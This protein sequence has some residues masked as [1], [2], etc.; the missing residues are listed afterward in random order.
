MDGRSGSSGADVAPA[1]QTGTRLLVDARRAAGE[2]RWQEAEERLH[3]VEQRS[4][5]AAEDLELLATAASLRGDRD[6]ARRARLRAYQ[7]FVNQ[8]ERRRA[9]RCGALIGL[10]LLGSGEL[11]EATGCLPMSLSACSAWVGQAQILL[12]GEGECAE[13]G[14]VLIPA[15]YEQLTVGTD[16]E[17][18]AADAGEAVELG[19]RFGEPAVVALGLAIQGRARLRT[20]RVPEGLALL[21]DAVAMALG[22]ELPPVL[23]G[24]VLTTA[25]DAASETAEI[26]RSDEWT[27]AL[28]RW[29]EEQAGLV[30]FRCRSLALRAAS[31]LRHGRWDEAVEVAERAGAHAIAAVDPTA[32]ALAA[33]LRGEV[34]RLRAERDAAAAAYRRASELGRDPQPGLAL[35]WLDTG[36]TDAAAGAIERVLGETDAGLERARVLPARVEILLA[37]G[38]VAA[39]GAAAEQLDAIARQHPSPALEAM[40]QHTGATVLLEHGEPGVALARLRAALR[41]WRHLHLPY[42]EARTR[43]HLARCCRRLG[44][45][46]TAMIE[47]DVACGILTSLRAGPDLERARALQHTRPGSSRFGLTARESEVLRLLATGRTNREIADELTVAVRTVDTHVS[48]ILTKLGVSTRAAATA[49]AH[50]HDL[51]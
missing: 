6:G 21:D 20:G 33:Y 47:V 7:L 46:A 26:V 28:D 31:H 8:G 45:E 17:G 38:E 40:A 23:V 43:L 41:V 36:D 34:L 32:A 10:E 50:R 29:C 16:L 18:A 24:L 51:A 25:V 42:E 30:A 35:L 49:V 44:D 3:A 1:G 2:G 15:A 19:R 39:A 48:R 37:R 22:G 14:Y 13:R 5:L 4:A 9:A 27:A 11:A 12:S